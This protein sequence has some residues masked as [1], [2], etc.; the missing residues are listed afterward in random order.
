MPAQ[1]GPLVSFAILPTTKMSELV[2]WI[3]NPGRFS[4]HFGER[5]L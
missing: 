3:S 4:G 1:M 2:E 5:N